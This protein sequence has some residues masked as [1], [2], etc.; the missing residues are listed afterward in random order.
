MQLDANT[1][2]SNNQN[3]AQ[4]AATYLSDKSVD[5]LPL[6]S[7]GTTTDFLGG[8]LATPSDPGKT[9]L[10][11]LLAMVTTAFTSAGAATLQVN[12]VSADDAALTSNVTVLASTAVLA[13]TV[14]VA[15]YK[16]LIS[17]RLPPGITQRYIGLQYVIG[18][19]TTT[20]GNVWAGLVLDEET[21]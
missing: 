12:L 2:M 5:L 11:K 14:L 8:A 4:V 19:A 6:G 21:A 1:E 7:T 15:G 16:F 13:K 17:G 20:A 18:T 3:L 9:Q 10:M